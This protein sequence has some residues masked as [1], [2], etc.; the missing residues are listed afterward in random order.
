MP[1]EK[2]ARN[3]SSID[4]ITEGFISIDENKCIESLTDEG[5]LLIV[6]NSDTSEVIEE[7]EA[8]SYNIPPEQ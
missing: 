2:R 7:S 6:K 4:L 1:G 5:I 3:E 8:E